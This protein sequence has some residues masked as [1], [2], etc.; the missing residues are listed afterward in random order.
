MSTASSRLWLAIRLPDLALT[1]LKLADAT[2][3]PIVVSQN[4]RV[5]FTNA[6]ATTAG[7]RS[8]MDI[9]TA[10]LLSGCEVAERDE[11]KEHSAL[12]EL[13]GPCYQ[14]SPY[15]ERYY[16]SEL[17]QSALLLEVSSCLKL[18]GG[19][20]DLSARLFTHLA[21]TPYSFA[22]GLAHTPA[23]AWYLSFQHHAITG[24]E[25]KPVFV[26]RLHKLRVEA[27][28]DWPNAVAALLKTGFKTF[29]DLATQI[30]GASVGSLKKRL[31]AA[32]T[33]AFC[34][35]YD[36]DQHFQQTPLFEPPRTVYRP[37]EYFER[38]M[39][40]DYPVTT[41]EQLKPA[42]DSLLQDLCSYLRQRQQHCHCIEWRLADIYR[43]KEL[44]TVNSDEPSNQ[45]QLFY[46]LSIILFENKELPFAV[47]TLRLTC[48][49]AVPLHSENQL[50][51]FDQSRRRTTVR[52]HT[53]M[54]ARLKARLGERAVYKIG[55][56]DSRVP[57]ITQVMLSLAE[58]CYQQ[59]PD[60]HSKALRPTWLFTQ[61][62][63]IETRG[64][65]LHW[66][67]YLTT[68]A[69]PE[70]IIGEWWEKRLARDYFL[71]KRQDHVPVWIYWDLY[72]KQ[73]YVHGVFA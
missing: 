43:N 66:H 39:Q 68:L 2:D 17:A 67:G 52:D 69:G 44:V 62:E 31:G 4:K 70:R 32:F 14:F 20:Q 49:H 8:G 57:E 61:P 55:Y 60:I 19:L 45:V 64:G 63:P 47:D 28:C 41:T 71:A 30:D 26:E 48:R 35:I 36:I 15:L 18:F 13:S 22:Y 6:L 37:E 38:D 21:Q 59:L 65:R 10:Q 73:W 16:S 5:I 11:E 56:R 29:G 46:D 42:I 34:A 24:E 72:G 1:A 54:I 23:A 9:T 33:E 50:L 3:R 12:S 40:F 58:Q 7:V 53:V 27:L 51:G 25:D